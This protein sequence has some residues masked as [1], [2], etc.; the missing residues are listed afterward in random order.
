[1]RGCLR[2]YSDSWSDTARTMR[3]FALYCVLCQCVWMY[4]GERVSASRKAHLQRSQ[5][6][7]RQHRDIFMTV[8]YGNPTTS[9]TRPE[10]TAGP[11]WT[12]RPPCSRRR[13]G[14]QRKAH[15]KNCVKTTK[16]PQT[17]SSSCG[18][19]C[20]IR[21]E[22]K[23]NR[24]EFIKNEILNELGF[25]APPKITNRS[26]VFSN[27]VIQSLQ[28]L[29]MDSSM[30]SQMQGDQ[31]MPGG[32][33]PGST[34]GGRRSDGSDDDGLQDQLVLNFS[35]LRKFSRESLRGRSLD[36]RDGGWR[37]DFFEND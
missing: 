26:D 5:S 27:P 6:E 15:R 3:L 22:I 12:R 11:R 31:P 2:H 19:R 33:V 28:S 36:F 20:K 1:M 13:K 10:R 29:V 9:S 16:R 34:G 14:R 37:V 21:E 32:F 18:P 30:G 7:V 25:D 35:V 23:R 17:T 24:I 4:H 8:T